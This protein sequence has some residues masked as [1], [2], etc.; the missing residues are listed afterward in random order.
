MDVSI[1]ARAIVLDDEGRVLLVKHRHDAATQ[2]W[3]PPGGGLEPG[4]SLAACA[5]REVR[6]ETGLEIEIERFIAIDDAYW[7]GLNNVGAWFL[8]R[9]IGGVLSLGTDPELDTKQ[10]LADVRFVD[11]S[12][13]AALG[14]VYP[15]GDWWQS[16]WSSVSNRFIDHRFYALCGADEQ[17]GEFVRKRWL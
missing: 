1:G 13:F 7:D 14:R 12:G 9:P 11:P 3:V 5:I 4:E 2:F 6:E 16:F 17:S 10:I 15:E 8:G